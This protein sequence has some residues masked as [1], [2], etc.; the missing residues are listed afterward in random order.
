MAFVYVCL[1]IC[2]YIHTYMYMYMCIYVSMHEH[3]WNWWDRWSGPDKV[4]ICVYAWLSSFL[5]SLAHE[6]LMNSEALSW[7]VRGPWARE[8]GAQVKK[9]LFLLPCCCQQELIPRSQLLLATDYKELKKIQIAER[10][11]QRQSSFGHGCQLLAPFPC[12]LGLLW[13]AWLDASS[14]VYFGRLN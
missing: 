2:T 14:W 3:L 12:L 8:K 10:N 1:S 5:F 7:P 11:C 9:F 13:D 4:C 6:E